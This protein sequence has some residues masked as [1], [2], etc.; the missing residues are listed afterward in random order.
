MLSPW[1]CG[2]T[3]LKRR[4]KN[5]F[6]PARVSSDPRH[7]PLFR[8][9]HP[10]LVCLPEVVPRVRA[11]T[12]SQESQQHP[13]TGDDQADGEDHELDAGEHEGDG[14][15]FEKGQLG[16]DGELGQA[17]VAHDNILGEFAGDEGG[18]VGRD[19]GGDDLAVTIRCFECDD[20]DDESLKLSTE[21][22]R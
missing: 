3:K 16:L 5:A 11:H 21:D 19:V 22:G 12:V 9:G 8:K 14:A 7:T 6:T 17:G 4:K 1:R 10:A 15:V 2:I 20:G 18:F 13:D